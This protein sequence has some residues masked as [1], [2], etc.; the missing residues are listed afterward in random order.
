MRAEAERDSGLEYLPGVKTNGVICL[1]PFSQVSDD[2]FG[3]D[4]GCEFYEAVCLWGIARV[5]VPSLGLFI[6]GDAGRVE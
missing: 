4:F 2:L 3:F 6:S 1:P 5:M